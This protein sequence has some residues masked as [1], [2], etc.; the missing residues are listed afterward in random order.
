[1]DPEEAM[2]EAAAG[3]APVEAHFPLV[4]GTVQ[5]GN[6]DMALG[7]DMAEV[8]AGRAS[9]EAHDPLAE[10]SNVSSRLGKP[11]GNAAMASEGAMAEVAAGGAPVEALLPP[12]G[13]ASCNSARSTTPCLLAACTIMA[14]LRMSK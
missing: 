4:K 1:M 13:G 12:V 5:P 11:L 2:A 9:V 7:Q 8:A 3:R 6:A 10:Y 14:R